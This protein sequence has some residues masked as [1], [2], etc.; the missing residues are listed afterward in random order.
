MQS[1]QKQWKDYLV[2]LLSFYNDLAVPTP[3]NP[4][5]THG[6]YAPFAGSYPQ[7]QIT[8]SLD[9]FPLP[10]GNGGGLIKN[11]PASLVKTNPSGTMG[12][13]LRSGLGKN[14]VLTIDNN[15]TAPSIGNV[16]AGV[17]WSILFQP[18]E[19]ITISH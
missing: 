12:V 18:G 4:L 5:P 2:K 17:L 15:G 16:T 1:Q 8:L 9:D 14:M 3:I 11:P 10:Y 7:Y 13:M 19:D 6:P